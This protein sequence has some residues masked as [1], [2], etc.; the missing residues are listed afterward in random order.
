M[1]LLYDSKFSKHPGQLQ[2]HWLGSYVINFI[3]DESAVQLQQLNDAMF[4]KLM[5][6]N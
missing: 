2:M 3:T 1:V 5:N 6:G 4:P